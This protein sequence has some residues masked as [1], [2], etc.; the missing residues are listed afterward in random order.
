MAAVVFD[1]VK[2][3]SE[4]PQ[5]AG[6]NDA[7]LNRLFAEAELIVPN[8]DGSGIP[9][10][11]RG[12]L[13]YLLVCHLAALEMRGADGGTGA[14][15]SATEGTV[16]VSFAQLQGSASDGWYNQTQC[17]ATFLLMWRGRAA[18]PYYVGVREVHPLG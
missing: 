1:P 7:V 3:R 8:T 15:A 12:I 11:R 18:G 2:F 9:E 6:L 13:L 5:F 4:R 16:N 14:V 10:A 17:G